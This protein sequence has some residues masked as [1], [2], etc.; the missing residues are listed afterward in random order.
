MFTAAELGA[1]PMPTGDPHRWS[2]VQRV[3][4]AFDP[5]R[6]GDL[7]VVLKEHVSTVATPAPGYVASHG[8]PWDYDRRVP[9]IFIAPGLKPAAPV[10]AIDTVD[11]LPTVARWVG[12]KLAPGSIDGT[13]RNEAARC[14]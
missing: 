6:S 10:A 5:A 7:Y 2:L 11:I 1:T 14:H 13:C 12:L 3:R 9:V 4:A 8:T